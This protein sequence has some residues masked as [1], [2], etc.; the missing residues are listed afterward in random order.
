MLAHPHVGTLTT[1]GREEVV[2]QNS[3]FLPQILI[4]EFN[5]LPE[6]KQSILQEFVRT[7]SVSHLNE[8]FSREDVAFAATVNEDDRGTYAVTPPNR[9]RFDVSI[10]FTHG[11]GWLQEHVERAGRNVRRDLS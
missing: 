7:G 1:A 11:A 10:E 2:W 6:G 4:D 8:V 3:L 9:D 5:R